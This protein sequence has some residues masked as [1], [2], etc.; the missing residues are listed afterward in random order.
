MNARLDATVA[1]I[2]A[3]LARQAVEGAAT[4]GGI[5]RDGRDLVEG[6]FDL[7]R[8]A[9][10]VLTVLGEPDLRPTARFGSANGWDYRALSPEADE[11]QTVRQAPDDASPGEVG[12]GA[13]AG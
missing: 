6:A 13:A 11:R 5:G 1:A 4:Y 8:V 9:Y 7:T 12:Q 3:E 2:R 10:A